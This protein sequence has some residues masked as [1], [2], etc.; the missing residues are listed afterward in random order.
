VISKNVELT[1][2]EALGRPAWAHAM[3][4]SSPC[5]DMAALSDVWRCHMAAELAPSSLPSEVR[6][7]KDARK[8]RHGRS[9]ATLSSGIGDTSFRK[10]NRPSARELEGVGRAAVLHWEGSTTCRSF[11]CNASWQLYQGPIGAFPA[12][13]VDQG[14]D[15]SHTASW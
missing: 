10:G 12:H 5:R 15:R 2:Q 3:S 14:L 9:I 6:H 11:G 1:I 8:L 7:E 13:Q 4:P